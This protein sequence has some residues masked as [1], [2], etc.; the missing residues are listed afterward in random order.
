MNVVSGQKQTIS[1]VS[2]ERSPLNFINLVNPRLLYIFLFVF[3]VR[4]L[5]RQQKNGNPKVPGNCR[6][7]PELDGQVR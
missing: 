3:S 2:M 1:G 5:L 6:F 7:V 4:V